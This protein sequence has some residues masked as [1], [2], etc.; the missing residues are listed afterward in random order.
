[1]SS[2]EVGT[3]IGTTGFRQ[4]ASSSAYVNIQNGVITAVGANIT[5]FLIYTLPI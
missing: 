3:Y 2:T 1:M 5:G 4:Y